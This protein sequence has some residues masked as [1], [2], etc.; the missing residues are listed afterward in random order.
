MD[1][2]NETLY[3]IAIGLPALANVIGL[4][5]GILSNVYFRRSKNHSNYKLIRWGSVFSVI[6]I[7]VNAFGG[8]IAF[9]L[10]YLGGLIT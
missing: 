5:L 8:L 6:A 3:G 9:Y 1:T 4:F 7:V 10:A 2:S